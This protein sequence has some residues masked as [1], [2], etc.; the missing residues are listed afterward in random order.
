MKAAGLAGLGMAG[1]SIE[2]F[3]FERYNS[4]EADL[5][6][7]IKSQGETYKQSFNMA[8][9]AAPKIPMVRI[10]II[11]LG[12]RGS[13]HLKLLPKIDGLEIK[14]ICDLVPEIAENAG[15]SLNGTGHKPDLYAGDRD[16]WKKLCQRNDIDVVYITTPWYMH[17]EMA[18]YAMEQGKHA[19]SEVPAAGT[20]RECW[21]LV[22][23]SERTRKHC[24]IME[25]YVYM[26]FQLL[27]LNM[28]HNGFFGEV[29]HGEGAYNTS[30]MGNNFSKT[31]YWDMWWLR[32][33]A[34][35]KGN[36][37]P[38]H[39]LG[40][41]ALCMD[42]NHGDRL[43][44]IVSME[45]NDFMM[46]K[47]AKE[48][49]ETDDF[50]RPFVGKDFRGN[51]NV[52]LIRTQ[53][54]RTIM[55]QHDATTP[56]PHNLIHGIYGTKGAALFDPPPPKLAD[57]NHEWISSEEFDRLRAKYTPEIS[58]R[59]GDVAKGSGHGDAD[60]LMEWRLIDCLHNGLPMP[61]NVY[62]AASWSSIVPLSEW[63]VHHR[64]Y[65]I[66]IPDFTAG[67]WRINKQQMDINLNKGGDTKIID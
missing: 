32:Q 51:M 34:W 10:G 4:A 23:T 61:M 45:S 39:G 46:E 8:D 26:P 25:N 56:S 42:I 37:Y 49:A 29:V 54:G 60:L 35:R 57:G 59:M 7:F 47:K 40:P 14:A 1:S 67:A 16:E 28:S 11:G 17:A 38:T 58:G 65:P 30:K 2:S 24:V 15:K 19:F 12:Q 20:I 52:S 3:A 33:Y 31:K 53:T 21:Q 41:I 36:F 5:P 43:D 27:M 13:A 44:Y 48:L 22:E 50:Y 63:S 64:S 6:Q 66:D 18:L 9:Y 55:L 62:D